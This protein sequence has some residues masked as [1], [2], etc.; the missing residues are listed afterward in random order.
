MIDKVL[1]EIKILDRSFIHLSGISKIESF[2]NEEFLL[3]SNMGNIHIRGKDLEV[4][5]MDTND[6]NV[7]IKGK[8][9]SL[10][11]VDGK[12]KKKEDSILSKLFK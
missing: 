9:D 5:K 10:H 3:E 4:I 8:I 11:Y 1:H 7:K 12:I 6:G 2:N